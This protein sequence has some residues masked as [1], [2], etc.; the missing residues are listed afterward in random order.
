VGPNRVG[1]A[2][3]RAATGHRTVRRISGT[4]TRVCFCKGTPVRYLSS[5]PLLPCLRS[6]SHAIT[7]HHRTR[8]LQLRTFRNTVL[9][10]PSNAYAIAHG[11][12][13]PIA[14]EHSVFRAYRWN[15]YAVASPSC[16][17]PAEHS[18]YI[19]NNLCIR[20]NHTSLCYTVTI[21]YSSF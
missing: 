14:R 6:Y 10:I 13:T 2:T 15:T 4:S 21:G 18:S 17:D 7:A 20:G 12:A 11:A 19:T 16:L 8:T 1:G 9:S 3:D 5:H